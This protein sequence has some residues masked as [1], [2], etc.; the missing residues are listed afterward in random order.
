MSRGDHIA[1]T[2]LGRMYRGQ[3]AIDFY[4]KRRIGM[5]VAVVVILVTFV[6]LFTRGLNLGLDLRRPFSDDDGA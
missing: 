5:I 3:T 6:S 2:G 4:G 1:A